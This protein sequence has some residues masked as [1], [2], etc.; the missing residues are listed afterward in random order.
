MVCSA[1][2]EIKGEICRAVA[3]IF[4]CSAHAEIKGQGGHPSRPIS[5]LL[6]ARG[7]QRTAGSS[8]V[9][10]I[11]L[12]RARGDQRITFVTPNPARSSAPRTRRSKGRL[13]YLNKRTVVCSAHAEIKGTLLRVL[14]IPKSLLRARGDQRTM[15]PEVPGLATSAPRVRR[16]MVCFSAVGFC[17]CM[18]FAHANEGRCS[19][20][21]EIEWNSAT[22]AR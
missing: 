9:S 10:R 21:A 7:D 8:A 11:G 17:V 2:A 14:G 19:A 20:Y 5:S 15:P 22:S 6:R 13:G 16:S 3:V 1:H 18:S 4:V 12:L